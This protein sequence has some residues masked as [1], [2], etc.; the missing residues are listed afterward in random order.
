MKTVRR[1]IFGS[2]HFVFHTGAKNKPF[3]NND[4]FISH[5]KT[6][7]RQISVRKNQLNSVIVFYLIF[8]FYIRICVCAKKYSKENNTMPKRIN[9]DKQTYSSEEK[10]WFQLDAYSTIGVFLFL[11]RSRA[12]LQSVSFFCSTSK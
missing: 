2:V 4:W 12:L 7:A 1:R 3:V 11:C 8:L 10:V 9:L 5:S 6:S